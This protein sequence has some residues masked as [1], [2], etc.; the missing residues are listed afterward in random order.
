[1]MLN[2]TFGPP[3]EAPS[4]RHLG[5]SPNGQALLQLKELYGFE[6]PSYELESF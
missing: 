1:M 3:V 6:L 5:C 2:N 4:R